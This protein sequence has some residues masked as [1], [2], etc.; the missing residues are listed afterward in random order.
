MAKVP[1]PGAS[2]TRLIP[3]LGADGA[4][5]LSSCFLRDAIELGVSTT[6]LVAGLDV[7]VA[8]S[9]P[10]QRAFFET[11]ATDLGHVDQSG[12]DLSER[13]D[14]VLADRLMAGYDQVVSINSDSP[15]LQASYL[16]E[17]FNCLDDPSIDVVFGPADDG[18]YYL[19][20]C[21]RHHPSL[22]QDVAMSTPTVLS[23][24]LA[25]ADRLG[26]KVALLDSWYDVD[27][28]ADLERLRAEI[29]EGVVCGRHTARF[30]ET[31][32]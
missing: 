18:G 17:A 5:E 26:L 13:L 20:G 16:A 7:F 19:I 21:R 1:T 29:A 6:A 11:L 8:G 12:E 14:H 9:P 32:Q 25:V 10:G 28:P 23:D 27:E 2:K 22:V 24:S 4:A 30:L 31:H 3:A 15:T